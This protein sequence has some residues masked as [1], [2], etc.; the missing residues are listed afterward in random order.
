M[1]VLSILVGILFCYLI[2]ETIYNRI[3]TYCY[4]T[5]SSGNLLDMK[6]LDSLAAPVCVPMLKKFERDMEEYK[7]EWEMRQ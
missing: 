5:A 2:Y 1:L 3:L 7:K 6:S 4:E